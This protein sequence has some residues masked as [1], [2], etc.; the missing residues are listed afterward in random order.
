MR[1]V[2]ILVLIHQHVLIPLPVVPEHLRHLVEEPE[3]GQEQVVEVEGVRL[4]Q[5]RLIPPIDPRDGLLV[6]P[7]G[8]L[9]RVLF[10]EEQLILGPRDGSA[11][12]R[13]RDDTPVNPGV[14]HAPPDDPQLVVAVV[15]CE[16]AIPAVMVDVAAEPAGAH[17]VER[18]TRHRAACIA[19]ERLDAPTHLAGSLVR[20]RDGH[21]AVRWHALFENEVGDA[22]RDDP[23][24]AR[25]G[26]GEDQQRPGRRRDCLALRR[27][28]VG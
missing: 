24:L 14:G 4:L 9:R 21:Q 18:A 10:G 13:R 20:E 25:T 17:G 22:V 3:R 1:A 12:F 6:G 16:A 8:H 2:R 28:E 11:N 15:D 7:V 26:A 27:I 5:G 23:R 19:D